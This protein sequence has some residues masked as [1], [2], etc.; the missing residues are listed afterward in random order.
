MLYCIYKAQAKRKKIME[1][2]DYLDE[3][4]EEIMSRTEFLPTVLDDELYNAIEEQGIYEPK[5]HW[6]IGTKARWEELQQKHGGK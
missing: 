6:F 5:P 1:Y 2:E 4:A 3:Q